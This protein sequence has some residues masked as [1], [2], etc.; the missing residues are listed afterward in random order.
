MRVTTRRGRHRVLRKACFIIALLTLPSAWDA[1]EGQQ[2]LRRPRDRGD[3]PRTHPNVVIF[4]I[5]TLR[6]DRLGAYG[7]TER[8]TS[9]RIDALARE[10][11]LFERAYAPAPWTLPSVVSTAT[12]LMPGEHG[13]L[14]DRYVMSEQTKPQAERL[15]ALSYRTI[16]LYSNAYSG[17]DFNMHRGFDVLQSPKFTDGAKVS[18]VFDDYLRE[19]FYLFIHNI[20][21]HTPHSYAPMQ[22]QE[23]FRAI[24]AERRHEIREHYN[25]YRSLTRADFAANR[26][27]GSTDNTLEQQERLRALTELRED[28]C[29]LYDSAVRMADTRVGEVIDELRRRGI[30][31]KTIFIVLSD[32]G[33]EFDEHGG[34][35]HDQSVYE[36]LI[37]VPLLIR[38]PQDAF[39]GRRVSEVVSLIDLMPTIFQYIG[40]AKGNRSPSGRN[41]MPLIRGED[42]TDEP[43]FRVISMRINTKKYFK[44]WK[45]TRGD[46]NIAVRHKHWKGIWNLEP[47]TLE[48]YDLEADPAERKNLSEENLPLA[49]TMKLVAREYWERTLERRLSP[50]ER[51]KDLDE[52][53]RENLRALGYMD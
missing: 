6:A 39:G 41:L 24:S 53:T 38:F 28:Y 42:A 8:P 13:T 30:W 29:E 17:Q 47:D 3:T 12:S 46:I 7:Y 50:Q 51:E 35:L 40:Y 26:P 22:P 27:L 36:E 31:D 44:P 21:P 32:H 33:E 45:E 4:M 37:H 23:G 20:E 19:P 43:D 18:T 34:W 48:L 25:A 10:S 52:H 5:D 2:Q 9:P 49:L 1:V 14:D 15:R 16:N 11:V